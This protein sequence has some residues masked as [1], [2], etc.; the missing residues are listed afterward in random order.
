MTFCRGHKYYE[1]ISSMSREMVVKQTAG[2]CHFRCVVSARIQRLFP[3]QKG[4][5][6][7]IGRNGSIPEEA[8]WLQ[9]KT[10][11]NFI[12]IRM[13]AGSKIR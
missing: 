4:V 13:A 1:E 5:S 10:L 2:M 12:I 7:V 3:M 11:Q 8:A 6:P 9:I